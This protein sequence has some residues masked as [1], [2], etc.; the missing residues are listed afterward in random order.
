MKQLM[1]C[2][3][4][5]GDSIKNKNETFYC[6]IFY[7]VI[8]IYVYTSDGFSMILFYAVLEI[9]GQ[10]G[11]ILLYVFHLI[12]H[13]LER[14]CIW[15]DLGKGRFKGGESYYYERLQFLVK[16]TNPLSYIY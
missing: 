6:Y 4:V 9:T 14:G 16:M 11:F 8:F 3:E 12:T 5:P 15:N 13:S 7:N 10:W 2:P 1:T